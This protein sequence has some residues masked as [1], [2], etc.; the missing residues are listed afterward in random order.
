MFGGK[1]W[2]RGPAVGA[3]ARAILSLVAC[4]ND[5]DVN[6]DSAT[7]YPWP[8]AAPLSPYPGAQPTSAVAPAE[9]EHI[10]TSLASPLL[11]DDSVNQP[12][13]RTRACAP[14]EIC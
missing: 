3:N 6:H 1:V 5:Q 8:T 7:P 11:F 4:K 13:L 9:L 14:V 10:A 2:H 12:R